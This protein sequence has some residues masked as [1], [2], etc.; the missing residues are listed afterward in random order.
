MK[1]AIEDRVGDAQ[2][3]IPTF[4]QLFRRPQIDY[5][6]FILKHARDLVSANLENLR[7]LRYGI[8]LLLHC[9]LQPSNSLP[10]LPPRSIFFLVTALGAI[11]AI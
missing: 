1:H 11:S 5:T 10:R 9:W 3:T 6:R 7:S 2:D 4:V 8:E